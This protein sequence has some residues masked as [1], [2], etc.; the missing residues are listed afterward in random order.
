[1]A[2]PKKNAAPKPT[3]QGGSGLMSALAGIMTEVGIKESRTYRP[4]PTGINVLD[5]Y[6]ARY[7]MNHV[8]KEYELFTGMPMG[9]LIL[10]IGYTGTGKEQNVNAKV[11]TPI[12]PRRIGD[13]K[14]GDQVFARNGRPTTVTGVYPQG[15]KPCFRVS[16]RDGTSTQ[17]GA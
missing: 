4:V 2:A 13:L 12:G 1:M 6:N 5:F 10:K 11:Q 15:T 16:F 17:A 3:P 7:F 9:K 14:V 8:S